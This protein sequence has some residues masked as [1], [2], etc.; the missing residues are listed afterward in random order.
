MLAAVFLPGD[1]TRYQRQSSLHG[2]VVVE[3]GLVDISGGSDAVVRLSIILREYNS[4]MHRLST[5]HAKAGEH[6]DC[7]LDLALP[8]IIHKGAVQTSNPWPRT[9]P[10]ENT[11]SILA[12]DLLC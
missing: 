12:N 1:S 8:L 5:D 10:A 2:A 11:R 7:G 6:E 3:E 9:S 4:D